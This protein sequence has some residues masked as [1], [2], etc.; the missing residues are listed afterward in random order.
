MV[1][2]LPWQCIFLRLQFLDRCLL[3]DNCGCSTYN[4]LYT[5]WVK[6]FHPCLCRSVICKTCSV[7]DDNRKLMKNFSFSTS[8]LCIFCQVWNDTCLHHFVTVLSANIVGFFSLGN[9]SGYIAN[10]CIALSQSLEKC[11]LWNWEQRLL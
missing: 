3:S 7:E 10:R 2:P 8:V 9:R 1:H 4:V 5:A 11:V 6:Y